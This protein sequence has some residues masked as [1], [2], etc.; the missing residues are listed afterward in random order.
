MKSGPIAGWEQG[1]KITCIHY[2]NPQKKRLSRMGNVL[3]SAPAHTSW[4]PET[5]T[6]L[7]LTVHLESDISP[8]FH[9]VPAV[10]GPIFEVG[11]GQRIDPPTLSTCKKEHR[12]KPAKRDK[13]PPLQVLDPSSYCT[14]RRGLISLPARK[15]RRLQSF[16]AATP[17]AREPGHAGQRRQARPSRTG[18]ARLTELLRAPWCKFAMRPW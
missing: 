18:R 16:N 12:P 11:P 3:I 6:L 1:S 10:P 9:H 13:L 8:F 15:S 14:P 4:G 17:P 7:N 5:V 2:P